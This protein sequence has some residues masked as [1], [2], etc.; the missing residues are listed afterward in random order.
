MCD[1]IHMCISIAPKYAVSNVMG[2]L[3]GTECDHRCPV[4]CRSTPKFRG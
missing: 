1:H 2:Y 3:K 4:I